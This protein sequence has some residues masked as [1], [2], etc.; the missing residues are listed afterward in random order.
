[1]SFL[2]F[3]TFFHNYP[4][5]VPLSALVFAIVLKG[6]IH[7]LKGRFTVHKMFGSGGMPS[8]HSTFVVALSTAMGIK[9]GVWTDEFTICLVFSIIII[10]DAM[11]VRYQSGLHARAL[12]RLTPHDGEELNESMGHTPIEALAG[13]IVGFLT[14]VIL[15]GI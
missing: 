4:I 2:A 7:A 12:N 9:Y 8:A 14:A 1:M 5:A 13:G 15:L 11:N 10:Y 3:H 6:F